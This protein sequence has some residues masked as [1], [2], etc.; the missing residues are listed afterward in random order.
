MEYKTFRKVR[1]AIFEI[2]YKGSVRRNG[3]NTGTI[4]DL[5]R[6][7]QKDKNGFEYLE[8][9]ELDESTSRFYIHELVAKYFIEN[10]PDYDNLY[11][12]HKN[13]NLT[14]N[15]VGN[16]EYIFIEDAKQNNL[17]FPVRVKSKS[18]EKEEENIKH[19]IIDYNENNEDEEWKEV[20]KDIEISNY[21]Y[22]RFLKTKE[23]IKKF[24]LNKDLLYFIYFNKRFYIHKQVALLFLDKPFF[25]KYVVEHIDGNK[26]NNYY[27]NL[28]IIPYN[29]KYKYTNNK[30]NTDNESSEED[31]KT[32]INEKK[33]LLKQLRKQ[34]LQ[35]QL[36]ILDKQIEKLQKLPMTNAERQK[37]YREKKKN[38]LKE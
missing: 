20:N 5:D 4:T 3:I 28:Q 10:K 37:K 31:I 24:Y 16:L 9:T 26:L 27:K 30:N 15:W 38:E 13:G 1:G 36:E 29:Q 21:G 32:D 34:K 11:V 33:E 19:I 17:P 2:N 23:I 8:W 22:L 25:K 12:R 18:E 6:K 7:K 14:D 35:K